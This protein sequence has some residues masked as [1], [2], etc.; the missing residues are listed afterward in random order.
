MPLL[1]VQ[2]WERDLANAM[3][4]DQPIKG[5]DHSPIAIQIGSVAIQRLAS[6]V[7]QVPMP[8]NR[9]TKPV[10]AERER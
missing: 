1:F 4:L 9:K 8:K 3:I 2:L 10:S 5:Q 6:I 7:I